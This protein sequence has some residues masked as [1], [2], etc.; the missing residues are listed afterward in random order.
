MTPMRS[1]PTWLKI[2]VPAVVVLLLMGGALV[3]LFLEEVPEEARAEALE[4]RFVD[5]LA[6][7]RQ[8][9]ADLPG[10]LCSDDFLRPMRR[11]EET[12]GASEDD[13]SAAEGMD[14][15][16]EQLRQAEA[17]RDAFLAR[18]Q[19][20]VDWD[21]ETTAGWQPLDDPAILAAEILQDC[22][23][24]RNTFGVKPYQGPEST[25][26]P[27]MFRPRDPQAPVT[28]WFGGMSRQA[29]YRVRVGG[30]DDAPMYIHL[31]VDLG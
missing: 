4:E 26:S 27:S 21:K 5:Q 9:A 13:S 24:S 8:A 7:L 31:I 17:D 11:L 20:L 25:W 2:L 19:P 28:L 22:N 15:E 3:S 12:P 6:Y 18:L 14:R 30:P 10:D 16:R 29:R 23:G 1:T